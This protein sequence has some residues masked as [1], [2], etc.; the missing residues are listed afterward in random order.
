M[1]SLPLGMKPGGHASGVQ[2]EE[3]GAADVPFGQGE[4]EAAEGPE[5]VLTAHCKH[6]A[7]PLPNAKKP[8]WH[9]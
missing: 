9:G 1:H 2:A 6:A 4:H 8:G 3:P 7:E 5:N